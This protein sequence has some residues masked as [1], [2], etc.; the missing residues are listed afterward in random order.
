MKKNQLDK[1]EII[2]QEINHLRKWIPEFQI[3]TD[4]IA[5]SQSREE[6]ISGYY[7][8]EV[9]KRSFKINCQIDLAGKRK[10]VFIITELSDEIYLT[11]LY[12][13]G[14]RFSEIEWNENGIS[15]FQEKKII[16][17]S[18]EYIALSRPI[19]FA[20]GYEDDCIAFFNTKSNFPSEDFSRSNLSPKFIT[21]HVKKKENGFEYCYIQGSELDL[22]E[23]VETR[24]TA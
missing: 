3:T 23:D 18:K 4:T 14:S 7:D 19:V 2:D 17:L 5:F 20:V 1:A 6:F 10:A 13:F 9:L 15:E 12:M 24:K 21:E 16:N 8:E 22:E 11:N